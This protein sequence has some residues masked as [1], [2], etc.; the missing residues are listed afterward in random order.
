[1]LINCP[2]PHTTDVTRH[3]QAEGQLPDACGEAEAGV[4]ADDVV[5]GRAGDGDARVRG[6]CARVGEGVPGDLAVGESLYLEAGKP[7]AAHVREVV[8][9]DDEVRA[10]DADAGLP[11]ARDVVVAYRHVL[12]RRAEDVDAVRDFV[13]YHAGDAAP[14][15]RVAFDEHGA[16]VRR[17]GAGLNDDAVAGDRHFGVARVN[18][19]VADDD[20]LQV[21]V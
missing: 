11:R 17:A 2:S 18:R 10:L 20:V 13:R 6:A 19:V 4:V 16:D 15:D 8:V 21:V 5:A 7:A 14:D 3:S 1:M 12:H 9:L